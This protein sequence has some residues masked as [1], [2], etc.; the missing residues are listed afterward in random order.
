MTRTSHTRRRPQPGRGCSIAALLVLLPL[1]GYA[2]AAKSLPPPPATPA[3]SV[4]AEL[5]VLPVRVLDSDGVFV[6]GLRAGNFRVY[7]SGRLQTV[8]L[9]QQEDAP[10]TVG[11]IVDHSRSMSP[12]LQGVA[13]AV[14]SFAHSSNPQD[15][16]FVVDFN[17]NVSLE[18]PAGK[19][20]TH[21]AGELAHAVGAVSARGQTALYD[22]VYEGINHLQLAHRDKKA[23][24]VVSD[25]GDNASKH[26][27]ADV[28]ALARRSQTVIYAIGLIGGASEEENP[29]VLR[30]LCDETGGIAFFPEAAESV[31]EVSTRIAEDLREQYT[32]GF[33]PES[34]DSRDSYRKIQVKVSAPGDGKLR[35]QTRRGYVTSQK[36]AKD[37]S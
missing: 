3:I 25:G 8:N 4:T 5:V 22:A 34:T 13:A 2:Q 10:V 26:T 11:L 35:V 24:V 17:D 12:K 20:F 23:L 31:S 19:P 28:L 29:K 16:M 30:R 21:D 37:P 33:T 36:P 27:L 14:I 6:S 18:S 32:L 9:F 7:E 1:T 15:E